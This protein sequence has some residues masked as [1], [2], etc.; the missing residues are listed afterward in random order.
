MVSFDLRCCGARR[1]VRGDAILENV[2]L[3]NADTRQYLARSEQ[4]ASNVERPAADTELHVHD[5]GQYVAEES[6]E[7]RLYEPLNRSKSEIRV[8][9]L[10]YMDL[11]L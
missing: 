8:V 11:I 3:D 10:E 9:V 5:T 4:K 2:E 7:P 1:R 6:Q